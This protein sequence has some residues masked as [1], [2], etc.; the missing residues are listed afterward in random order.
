[1]KKWQALAPEARLMVRSPLSSR[2]LLAL[3][4]LAA[5]DRA[6]GDTSPSPAPPTSSS[7]PLVLAP[8]DGIRWTQA[9]PGLTDASPV[10]RDA[11]ARGRAD[12]RTVLVYVG[13]AWCEPCQRF[14]HAVERGELDAAFPRLS[15]IAFDADSDGEAL[16]SAGYRSRLIPLFAVPNDDGRSSGRQIEGSVKGEAA[17]GEITPRL[18]SLVNGS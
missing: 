13:A 8:R 18:R 14:H 3:L 1:M 11:L 7:T 9:P 17:V 6:Q 12:G 2:A 5:C 15:V 4:A 10:V 16:A